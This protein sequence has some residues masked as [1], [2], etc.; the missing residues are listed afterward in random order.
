MVELENVLYEVQGPLALITINRADKHNAISLD[1][2]AELQV[3]V[4]HAGAD[5][6]VRVITVT[7]AGERSFAS[8]SDLS[9]VLHRDFKKALEPIVQGLAERSTDDEERAALWRGADTQEA[10][11]RRRAG[12]GASAPTADR[13]DSEEHCWQQE[14]VLRRHHRGR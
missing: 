5:E 1:T 6:E 2:L 4:A 13:D 7:G 11:T 12:V 8:G 14:P 9:E 10:P 3:A